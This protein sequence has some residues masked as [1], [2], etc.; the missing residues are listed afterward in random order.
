MSYFSEIASAVPISDKSVKFRIRFST[1]MD[2]VR[3]AQDFRGRIFRNGL[4]DRDDLDQ[5][6]IHGIMQSHDGET[7][8]VFRMRIVEGEA[9]DNCYA[10][11]HYELSPIQS[12]G[13]KSL[14]IGRFCV[15]PDFHDPDIFRL[16]WAEIA[17]FVHE[18]DIQLLFG[19]TSFRGANILK[20]QRALSLLNEHYLGPESLRPRAKAERAVSFNNILSFGKSDKGVAYQNLPPLLRAYLNMGGWVSD[21]AVIDDDLDT[22]HVFTGVEIDKI[23]NSR[24]KILTSL[25]ARL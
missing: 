15:N 19:C 14:E 10:S 22:L 11:Q 8:C 24:R 16:A 1:N 5:N 18:N 20:H 13:L 7:V 9:F 4:S 25:L 21:H 3:R 12:S 23:P 17:K 2:D 6:A